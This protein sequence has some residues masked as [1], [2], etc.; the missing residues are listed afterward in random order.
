MFVPLS[1][2][3]LTAKQKYTKHAII[4]F[5]WDLSW[6]TS[7]YCLHHSTQRWPFWIFGRVVC[8]IFLNILVE[9][10]AMFFRLHNMNNF[11]SYISPSTP[12]FLRK[13]VQM[14]S[15]AQKWGWMSEPISSCKQ[16]SNTKSTF[17]RKNLRK[18]KKTKQ[19]YKN[20]KIKNCRR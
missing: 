2:T 19:A 16:R 15:S 18:L 20:S 4:H 17:L 3:C 7:T 6:Y 9:F 11:S 10:D 14:M 5:V 1:V 13:C 8:Q 12:W